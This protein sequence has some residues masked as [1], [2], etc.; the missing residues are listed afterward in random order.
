[1]FSQRDLHFVLYSRDLDALRVQRFIGFLI[2]MTHINE[3]GKSGHM[4]RKIL[5]PV[6]RTTLW[7]SM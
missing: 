1:M 6:T 5:K 3:V 7:E 2:L 4:K